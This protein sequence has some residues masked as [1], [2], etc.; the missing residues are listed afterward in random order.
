MEL[1]F[2]SVTP[3][4]VGSLACKRWF[5]GE[6]ILKLVPQ[7]FYRERNF[8]SA[9]HT[10]IEQLTDPSIPMPSAKRN[11]DTIIRDA[12]L[13]L[14]YPDTDMREA[15]I[16]RAVP[17]VSNYLLQQKDLATLATEDYAGCSTSSSG[18]S[19][20]RF[21]A[22]F[23][24][25]ILRGTVLVIRDVKT[26]RYHS[27]YGASASVAFVVATSNLEQYQRRFDTLFSDVVL[28]YAFLD[29]N[30]LANLVKLKV[31]DIGPLWTDLKARIH[32]VYTS[33]E[34]PAEPGAHC[35]RCPFR[36]ACLPDAADTQSATYRTIG[37]L[38]THADK[39]AMRRTGMRHRS[40]AS[41]D[42]IKEDDILGVFTREK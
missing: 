19:R 12:F 25:L 3:S 34:F 7:E 41:V 2:P 18:P 10:A 16:T 35:R 15:D 29:K 31:D 40:V 24:A 28:E 17:M 42:R 36:N 4:R 26:S 14:A 20:I 6:H 5:Y 27:V 13:G 30:G 39:S 21:G 9:V 22:R 8:G 11:V 33:V 37:P 38:R 32:E 23:D 1:L